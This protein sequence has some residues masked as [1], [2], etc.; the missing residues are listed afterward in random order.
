MLESMGQASLSDT[1]Q[2]FPWMGRLYMRLNPEWARRLIA[3]SIKH[4]S[5]TMDL[6]KRFDLSLPSP[7]AGIVSEM[8]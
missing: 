1:I 2:R 3:G 7:S 5:N 4:E 6:V 8:F